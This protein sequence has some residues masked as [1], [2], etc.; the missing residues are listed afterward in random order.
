C[1]PCRQSIPHLTELQKKYAG[2]GVI[3][4]GVSSEPVK[5]VIPFVASQGDN[6]AY[7]VAVDSSERSMRAWLYAYGENGIPHAFIVNT[8]GIVV[9]H[10]FPDE[11]LDRSLEELTSGT[12]DFELERNRETGERLLT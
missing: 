11:T 3:F 10:D 9:W 5:D 7:R 4:L 2:K 6:M 8:N 1:P 12:F